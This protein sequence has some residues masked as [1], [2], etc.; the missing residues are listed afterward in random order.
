MKTTST[1]YRYEVLLP[2]EE[3]HDRW[4]AEANRLGIAVGELI[5][6]SVNAFLEQHKAS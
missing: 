1:R 2:S 6:T 5:R 3:E 4:K